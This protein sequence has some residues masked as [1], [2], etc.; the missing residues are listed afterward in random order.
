MSWHT[1]GVLIRSDH[2]KDFPA[3]LARLGLPGAV[4]GEPV[5]FDEA[6]SVGN[7]GVAAGVVDGWTALWG[8]GVIALD[9]AA[10]AE[11]SRR[12]AVFQ[13]VLEGTSDTAGFG[14]W[15]GGER[16][17][18]WLHQGGELLRNEGDPLPGEKKAFAGRDR[19]QAVLKLMTELTVSFKKLAGITYRM[20]EIPE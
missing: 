2:S 18:D 17:R 15:V 3:L 6:T 16:V 19:E 13:V 11:I 1:N 10:F 5:D 4:E 9:A 20:Y 8:F 7:F 12:A 14:W